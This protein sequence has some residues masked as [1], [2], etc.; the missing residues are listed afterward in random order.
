MSYSENSPAD[1][2]ARSRHPTIAVPIVV[3][4]WWKNRAHDEIRL[5]LST[6]EG[7]NILSL[8]TWHTSKTDGIT[9][10][11]KGFACSIKHLPKL[12]EVFAEATKRAIELHL[13]DDESGEGG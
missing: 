4:K 5:E 8:R 3:S 6:H 9:R 2:P 7:T 12:S 1:K 11:G 13:I 10:P